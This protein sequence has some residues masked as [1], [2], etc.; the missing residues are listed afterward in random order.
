MKSY[1]VDVISDSKI[2]KDAV[3]IAKKVFMTSV[4]DKISGCVIP[5]TVLEIE[6]NVVISVCDDVN[7]KKR[8]QI[9]SILD[10][11]GN[12]KSIINRIGKPLYCKY[13]NIDISP[14]RKIVEFTTDFQNIKVGD[15]LSPDI[16]SDIKYVDV[17]STTKGKGF[18]GPMKLHG[19]SGGPA[20]HGSS[21]FHRKLGSVGQRSTPGRCFKLGKRASRMGGNVQTMLNLLIV[22][23]YNATELGLANSD[24]NKKWILVKGGVPGSVNSIVKIRAAVKKCNCK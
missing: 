23:V 13:K 2:S 16:F 12:E 20:S 21:L 4:F 15:I 1:D 8:V 18:Q 19:M 11:G 3:V 7:G 17:S 9:A 10:K 5:C 24:V 22:A 6:Q 14:M